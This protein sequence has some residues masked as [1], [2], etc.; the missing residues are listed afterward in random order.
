[1]REPRIVLVSDDADGVEFFDA[2]YID[3]RKV[4]ETHGWKMTAGEVLEH[5]AMSN[6]TVT[7]A[8]WEM[9]QGEFKEAVLP[10]HGF[11]ESLDEF[12][13]GSLER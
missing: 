13:E 11:P 6:I 8:L 9:A 4:A 5:V 3:G 7:Y 10:Q 2:L 12:P 1:M